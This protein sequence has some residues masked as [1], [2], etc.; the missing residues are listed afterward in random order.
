MAE[1]ATS[2][3][4]AQEEDTAAVLLSLDIHLDLR[5]MTERSTG[6]A[7]GETAGEEA[8]VRAQRVQGE[9]E[10]QANQRVEAGVRAT[11]RGHLQ[12]PSLPLREVSQR[13][14]RDLIQGGRAKAR[15]KEGLRSRGMETLLQLKR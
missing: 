14:G 13:K 1:E 6:R 15:V 7:T 12:G 11:L 5:L 2:K 3:E 9:V 8:T 4:T 10:A